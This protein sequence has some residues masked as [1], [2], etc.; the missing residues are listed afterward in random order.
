MRTRIDFIL[1]SER[2]LA[3]KQDLIY[4]QSALLFAHSYVVVVD[5]QHH[6]NLPV[7]LLVIQLLIIQED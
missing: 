2:P 1:T 7:Y 5:S 4:I 3:R 6:L